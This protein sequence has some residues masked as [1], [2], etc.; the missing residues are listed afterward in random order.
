MPATVRRAWLPLPVLG[1]SLIGDT[2]MDVDVLDGAAAVLLVASLLDVV[3]ASVVVV[4]FSVVDVVASLL[5]VVDASVLEVVDPSVEDVVGASVVDV[6][7]VDV[8]DVVDVG[9]VSQP[10]TQNT[11]CFT[12]APC[13]PS[14]LTVSLTCQPCWG[15][16]SKP[17]R[18]SVYVL[19]ASSPASDPPPLLSSSPMGTVSVSS[20]T[21]L[22]VGGCTSNVTCEKRSPSSNPYQSTWKVQPTWGSLSG[23]LSNSTPSILTV[24]LLPGGSALA[25][26][27]MVATRQTAPPTMPTKPAIARLRRLTS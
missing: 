26:P 8:V 18:S 6:V 24:P 22:P 20:T 27:G 12:S 5:D 2:P 16:C 14:L 11:L 17:V 10:V 3:D 4:S 7:D 19:D 9:G 25:W 15:C 23:W 1:S 21:S 13:D